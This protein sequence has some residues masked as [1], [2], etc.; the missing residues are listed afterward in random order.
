MVAEVKVLAG[1]FSQSVPGQYHF[2]VLTLAQPKDWI[3]GERYVVK[4]DVVTLEEADERSVVKVGGAAG[5]GTAGLLVAGPL[6]LLAGAL[7]GGKGQRVAFVAE[8][9]D[10][11]RLMAECDKKVWIKMKADRF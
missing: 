6:G 4:D 8:F 11:K 10:G 9:S 5:W 3:A 2:G 7:L 1:D